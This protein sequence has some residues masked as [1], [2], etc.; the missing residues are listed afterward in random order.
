MAELSLS[1]SDLAGA[2]HRALTEALVHINGV[3]SHA[4][5]AAGLKAHL[6][7]VLLHL[8]ALEDMQATMAQSASNG[9]TADTAPN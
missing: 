6:G 2:I 8:D 5:D 4:I 3:P 7:R 1:P 9:M